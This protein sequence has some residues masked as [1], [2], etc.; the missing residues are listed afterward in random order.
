MRQRT[1]LAG[2]LT[3]V[4]A[5]TLSML[6]S[7]GAAGSTSKKQRIA[8]E[9]KVTTT[10]LA[11]SG[12]FTLTPL[13][14]G[15]LKADSGTFTYTGGSQGQVLRN[16]Q[17]VTRYSGVDVLK[18]KHGTLRIP[19]STATVDAGGNYRVGTGTW[20]LSGGSGAYASLRGGGRGAVG[21]P[22]Q[23]TVFTR[24]EGYVIVR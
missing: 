6:V 2:A 12:T 16:G 14:P 1:Q 18:G 5:L 3:V 21:G 23:G 20:S 10:A 8:I 11:G 17:S 22:P 15:P 24:Y 4:A 19:N 7:A 13:T 9:E